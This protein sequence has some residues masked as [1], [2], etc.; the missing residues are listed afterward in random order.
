[1]KHKALGACVFDK[2]FCRVF[3]ISPNNFSLR[4]QLSSEFQRLMPSE[5]CVGTVALLDVNWGRTVVSVFEHKVDRRLRPVPIVETSM[6]Q[7]DV[8]CVGVT[9]VVTIVVL[10]TSVDAFD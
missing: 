2:Q 9:V 7:T 5:C 1:M 8:L 4:L 3:E 10:G 6:D